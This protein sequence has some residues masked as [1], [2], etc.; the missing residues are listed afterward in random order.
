MTKMT[1]LKNENDV[2]NGIRSG[3]ESVKRKRLH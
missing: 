2:G 3:E 1:S